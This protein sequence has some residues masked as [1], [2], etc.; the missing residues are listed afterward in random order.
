MRLFDLGHGDVSDHVQLE[1]RQVRQLIA[2][3]D[4][5]DDRRACDC[6]GGADS[7]FELAGLLGGET[8]TTAGSSEGR[9]V[10]EGTTR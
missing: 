9:K 2:S 8:M 10:W 5:I 1:M 4:R 3:D 6:K 7:L